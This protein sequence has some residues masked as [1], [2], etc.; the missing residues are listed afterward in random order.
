M[1]RKILSAFA[2]LSGD[3]L[4]FVLTLFLSELMRFKI[5]PLLIDV[6][7]NPAAGKGLYVFAPIWIAEFMVRG[8]YT[9]RNTFQSEIKHILLSHF[10][11]C[12]LLFAFSF[13]F[14]F[15]HIS[16]GVIVILSVLGG[17][18]FPIERYIIRWFIYKA[19][20]WGKRVIVVCTKEVSE[21]V[22][23]FV[24]NNFYMG[25]YNPIIVRFNPHSFKEDIKRLFKKVN[26]ADLI[27]CIKGIPFGVVEEMIEKGSSFAESIKIIPDLPYISLSAIEPQLFEGTFLLQV[28]INLAKPWN[29]WFKEVFDRLLGLLMIII[30]SPLLMFV[31]ILIYFDDGLPILYRQDRIGRKGKSFRL[32]K[33][34]TMF[35]DAD[36]R[37][38]EYLSKNPQAK[39]EWRRFMKLKGFD[40]RVTRT[41]R[42]LRKIS[43]DELPQLFNVLKGDMS[44]IGPRPYLE[45]ELERMGVHKD[46]IMR[47]KP[48]ITGLWQVSGRNELGFEERLKL[49]EFYVRNWSIWLDIYILM[50]T[51]WVVI[52]G[53]G[54]Y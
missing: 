36:T 27:I 14:R 39:E 5:L 2:L 38:D 29:R 34:R 21:T 51:V 23:N 45:R 18:I 32:Y 8:L 30:L 46:I 24:G 42:M 31:A 49:D 52:A 4:A 3:T 22:V 26:N 19:G 10:S 35:R 16:R 6:S 41:G 43:I 11:A 17:V 47:V 7:S 25:Y 53:R 20:I 28:N 12:V 50:K 44:L 33:F 9:R 15:F 40:P 13:L 48:G 37:L 54:A 1:I